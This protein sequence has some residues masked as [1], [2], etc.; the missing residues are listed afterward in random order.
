MKFDLA[1]LDFVESQ[2]LILAAVVPRPIALVSTVGENGIYNVAPYSNYG[3]LS[4]KPAVVYIGVGLKRRMRQRKDTIINIEFSKDFVLNVVNEALAEAMNQSAAE[5]DSDVSEFVETG[6][7]ALKS[8]L[9]KSPR[10]AESPISMECTLKEILRFG[11]SLDLMEIVLGEVLR[12]HIQDHLWDAKTREIHEF[13]AIARL[14]GDLY[15]R[16]TNAFEMKRP[17]LPA[18]KRV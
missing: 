15:C 10:V 6:L 11:D 1:D 8:D 9:V 13:N 16:T 2:R 12:I 4:M 5:Y 18:K 3:V 17:Q 7:T 14:G